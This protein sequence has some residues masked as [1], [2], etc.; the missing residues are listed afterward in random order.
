MNTKSAQVT[1]TTTN[2][3]KVGNVIQHGN[4]ICGFDY[5]TVVELNNSNWNNMRQVIELFDKGNTGGNWYG[6]NMIWY[7]VKETN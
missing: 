7:V 3:L 5:T 4:M 6:K 1:R 2:Q